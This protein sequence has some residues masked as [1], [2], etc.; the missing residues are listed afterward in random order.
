MRFLCHYDTWD[1][2]RDGQFVSEPT[3]VVVIAI[4]FNAHN[5]AQLVQGKTN[6]S[7]FAQNG[8]FM[9]GVHLYTRC[10]TKTLV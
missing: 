5:Q 4:V 8:E 1:V 10:T 2:F 6:D 3:N 9:N 7:F